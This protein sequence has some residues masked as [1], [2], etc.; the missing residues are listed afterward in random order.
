MVDKL[1]K[2]DVKNVVTREHMEDLERTIRMVNALGIGI[3]NLLPYSYLPDQ[4]RINMI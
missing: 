3:I 1:G 2:L 4:I